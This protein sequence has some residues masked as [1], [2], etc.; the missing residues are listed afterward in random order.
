MNRASLT[1]IACRASAVYHGLFALLF[2]LAFPCIG[3]VIWTYQ[4]APPGE[5]PLGPAMA[6]IIAGPLTALFYLPCALAAAIAARKKARDPTSGQLW[7]LIAG[8]AALVTCGPIGAAV[9]TLAIL[10]ELTPTT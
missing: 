9:L 7:M 3:A 5:D 1:L 4:L 6:M 2:G 8:G 10:D